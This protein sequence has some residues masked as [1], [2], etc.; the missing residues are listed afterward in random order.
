MIISL[1][2][3]N[4]QSF[5]LFQ[6]VCEQVP[7]TTYESVTRKKCRSVP[8][9]VC[10]D[11]QERKCQVTQRHVQETT[12]RK[13]CKLHY[14]KACKTVEDIRK[15]CNTIEDSV[16]KNTDTAPSDYGVTK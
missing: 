11:V 12:T 5:F 15:K 9:T 1:N 8:G 6:E 10:E 7:Q 2:T 4:N 14:K 3:K 16:A 13:E